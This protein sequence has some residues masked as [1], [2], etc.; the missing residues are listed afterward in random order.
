MRAKLTTLIAIIAFRSG[1]VE[2]QLG[3]ASYRRRNG[4]RKLASSLRRPAL[5]LAIGSLRL[6]I[7]GEVASQ[8]FQLNRQAADWSYPGKRLVRSTGHSVWH[9]PA[10]E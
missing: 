4:P 9:N 10:T 8:F 6:A 2:F 3:Q 5:R 1:H 7:D